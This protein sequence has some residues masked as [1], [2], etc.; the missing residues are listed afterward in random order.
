[1]KKGNSVSVKAVLLNLAKQENLQFQQILTRYLHERLLYR[2]SLSEY[3][4]NFVLKGGNLIYAIE[5][6]QTRPT[7]DIDILARNIKNDKENI[8]QIFKKI[9]GIIY[10]NDC[11]VFNP[12]TITVFDIA[13]EKKY[14]G[15]RLLIDT[16]FDTVRQTIQIDIGFSD[17][18]TPNAV[19]ISFPVLLKELDC[20]YILAYSIETIIAEKFHAMITLGN[21]NS[22]MKDLFDVHILLKNNKIEDESLQKAIAVT[23]K[24]RNVVLEKNPIFFAESYYNN[25]DRIIMWKAFLRKMNLFDDLDFPFVVKSIIERLQPIYNELYNIK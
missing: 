3:K 2:I 6:L 24:E 20:P 13:E 15:V 7:M 10:E 11:V 23:F 12:E 4:S 1:M 18:I 21:S 5:G 19:A 25:E 17:T 16:Q 14:S 22:R 9:F 8:K